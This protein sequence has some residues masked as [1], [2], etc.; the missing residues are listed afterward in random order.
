MPPGHPRGDHKKSTWDPDHLSAGPGQATPCTNAAVAGA[1]L[2][3]AETAEW[4]L[5]LG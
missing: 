4:T 2:G 3:Q 5:L 1:G